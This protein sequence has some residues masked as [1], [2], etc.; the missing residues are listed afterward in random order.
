MRQMKPEAATYEEPDVD[1]ELM[2]KDD[3]RARVISIDPE[4]MSG[5]PCFVGTR[6]PVKN[7]FDYLAAGDSLEVFLDAFDGVTRE[8]AVR[9]LELSLEHLLEGLP[10]R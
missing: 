9:T 7:L 1:T 5:A 6:V 3:L 10:A 4:R 2:P 8:Q